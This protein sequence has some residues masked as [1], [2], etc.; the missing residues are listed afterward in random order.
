M[1]VSLALAAQ[2]ELAEALQWLTER[3]LERALEFDAAYERLEAR[4]AANPKQFPEIEPGIHRALVPRFRY[5]V[6]FIVRNEEAVIVA[7]AHQSRRPG[8]WRDRL[9]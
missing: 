1:K 9:P 3:S 2:I 4:I 7:L 5:S 8:Y 6:F